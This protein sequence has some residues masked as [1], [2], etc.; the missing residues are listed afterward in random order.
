MKKEGVLSVKVDGIE[1][2]LSPQAL[3]EAFA[4]SDAEKEPESPPLTP[5]QVLLWSAPGSEADL[6]E[7]VN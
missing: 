2:Q 7:S 3:Q 6:P 1:V 5:E 4:S